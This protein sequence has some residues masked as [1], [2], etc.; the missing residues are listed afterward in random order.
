MPMPGERLAA[1]VQRLDAIIDDAASADDRRAIFPAM[2]RSVTA[3]VQEAVTEG[4]F[5]D[6]DG[7]MEEMTAGFADLYFTAYD[8]HAGTGP[9][10]ACWGMAFDAAA[11]PRYMILQHLLLGMNAHINHDLGIAT[12]RVG[13]EALET[14]YTDFIRVN[15]ILFLLLDDLQ[16]A[17][18][19][20]SPRMRMLDRVGLCIDEAFMRLGIRTARDLAWHFAERLAG[21][22]APEIEIGERDEDAARVG[23]LIVR[24]W[25]PLSIAARFVASK[26]DRPMTEVVE[27][28]RS[29]DIDLEIVERRVTVEKDR[30]PLPA[31]PLRSVV[32]RPHVAASFG[33]TRPGVR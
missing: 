32:A 29:V 30:S 23:R 14:V 22:E 4:G 8:A 6:D 24:T 12:A 27:A 25:S 33:R 1:T 26:E 15:E 13:R 19:E 2:Y 3:T 28:M 11:S 7:R 17:L 21:S 20:V 18:S 31:R 9:V 16:G 10:P 5:F